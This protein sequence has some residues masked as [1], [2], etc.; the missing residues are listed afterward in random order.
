MKISEIMTADPVAVGPGRPQ[1]RRCD[2]DRAPD[3]GR[4][5][6]RRAAR[7]SRRR[8]RGGH[9][10]HG[11][12]AGSSRPEADRLAPRRP[13]CRSA[14][15]RGPHRG[16]GDGVPAISVGARK[17]VAEAARLMTEH[18]I[19][20]L[21]VVNDEGTLTGIVTRTDLVR[22]FTRSDE[23]MEREI[24]EIAVRGPLARRTAPR[25]AGRA[26]RGQAGRQDVIG[27]RTPSFWR[28]W[29]AASREW[30]ACTRRSGGP[31][32]TRTR[33]RRSARGCPAGRPWSS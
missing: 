25:R 21:P 9:H 24:R 20:R 16:R 10:G 22:A 30:S 32:T 6:D 2:P 19:K 23:A 15:G 26:R 1:G 27:D 33:E 31:G 12:R 11:G 18:E 17:T 5:G 3:L 29:R 7:G 4:P 8:L 14:T 28:G 13:A